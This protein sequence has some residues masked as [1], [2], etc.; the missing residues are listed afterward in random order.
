MVTTPEGEMRAKSVTM[1]ASE[2]AAMARSLSDGNVA[3]NK[4]PPPAARLALR[5][6]RRDSG[7]CGG[8]VFRLVGLVAIDIPLSVVR[9]T[10]LFNGCAGPGLATPPQDVPAI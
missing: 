2:P 6:P 9:F 10:K 5:K 8:H 1:L 7:L 4:M 3:A